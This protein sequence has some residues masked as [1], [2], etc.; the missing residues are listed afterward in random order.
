MAKVSIVIPVYNA[1][2]YLDEC[3]RSALDQTYADTEVIAVDDGST[4]SSAEILGGYADRVRV[5][6][7]PNGGTASAL[8]RGARKMSGEWFKWLSADDLLRPRCIEVL[9]A[10]ATR[11]EADV[12]ARHVIYA[13]YDVVDERGRSIPDMERNSVDYSGL[14]AFERRVMLLYHC[15]CHGTASLFHRQAFE[16]CGYWDESIRP[17]EDYEFWLRLCL[18]HGYDMH[19]VADRVASVRKHPARLTDTT[20][21]LTFA[22]MNRRIKKGVIEMLPKDERSHY[23]SALARCNP[24]PRHVFVRRRLRDVAL[25]W[26]PEPLSDRLASSYWRAKQYVRRGAGA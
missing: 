6:C 14:S 7:K 12:A 19:Y 10:E 21:G 15:Y 18:V 9:T 4:D 2:K 23:M 11:P 3:V 1:E 8:N 24:E 22:K 25:E 16:R 17:Y 20:S 5:F 13:D 26:L